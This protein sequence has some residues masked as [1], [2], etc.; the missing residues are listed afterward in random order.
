[1][2]PVKN[3]FVP[4]AG[5][6]PPELAGRADVLA[7][8][9][10]SLARIKSG[11]AA[12]SALL[13]G[14]RG[15]GKTVLL[16]RIEEMATGSGYKAM[17]LEASETKPL[18]LLLFPALR[19]LLFA[20]DRFE[21]VSEQVKKG[22]RVLKSFTK[23]I[24]LKYGD[25]EVGLD[26]DEEQGTAD[27]GDLEADLADLLLAVA[28]AAAARETAVA[29]IIDEMQYIDETELSALITAVH[30]VS[31]KAL[32]LVLIGAGLPQLVGLVGRAR[33]YSERLFACPGIGALSP[34]DAKNALQGPVER[35]GVS[36]AEDALVE[37]I[38]VTEGYPY[39]IQEWGYQ[40]WNI[41][42]EPVITIDIVRQAEKQAIARL[43]ESFFR[44]R[45]DR[46]TP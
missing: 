37:I 32:P 4:G 40:A 10:V 21:N 30:K 25:F 44:I 31:Q 15:V 43:D 8:A 1:M 39:F 45:F 33:S 24:K 3:P 9:E 13:I 11:K 20:L 2:D 35:E 17:I 41:A 26:W 7:E 12:R 29:I 22:L 38:R 16:N 42:Q 23:A 5:S 6:P 28:Q 14:L 34:V 36:F 27:S 18:P 46:L 19:H